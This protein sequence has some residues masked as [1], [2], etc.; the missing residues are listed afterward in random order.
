[1]K[2]HA[3]S[4]L[5]IALTPLCNAQQQP[6]A[7]AQVPGSIAAVNA[8]ANQVS[9]KS[10][11]GETLQVTL[12]ERAL[13]LR[14]PPGETDANKGT[15]IALTDVSAGDRAVVV[16]PPSENGAMSASALL[17]MTKGDVATLQQKDQEEWKKRGVTGTV[18][19]VAPLTI[20]SGVHT[21]TVQP[22]TD[23]VWFRY[24]A[25]SARFADA[26]PSSLADVKTG[27]QLRV[28]GNKT[29]DGAGI[30]AEKIVFGTF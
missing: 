17:I 12:G 18:V 13:I 4:V 21:Y 26:K 19:A 28:L 11:K 15:K 30:K 6:R 10:D 22:G 1:M 14:I 27:D 25:A 20:K 23:T 8:P 29:D 16:G 7:R 24:S 3:L 5:I 9:L 2:L